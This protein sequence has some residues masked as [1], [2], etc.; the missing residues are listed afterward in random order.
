MASRIPASA[1]RLDVYKVA[2]QLVAAV[3][4]LIPRIAQRNSKLGTQLKGALP[5]VPQNISEGLRRTGNDR[6]HL[7]TVALGSAD[8]VRCVLEARSEEDEAGLFAGRV[9]RIS[10]V[11]DASTGTIKV[12]LSLESPPASVRPGTFMRVEIRKDVHENALLVSKR[13][14]VYEASSTYVFRTDGEKVER[15]PVA[16]GLEN[17]SNVEVYDYAWR[18]IVDDADV[19][20]RETETLEQLG[21]EC[22]RFLR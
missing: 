15:V 22:N 2:L 17:D 3:T 10:P 7:L 18:L 1:R 4:P 5:S 12:R 13:A 21:A 19:L 20:D 8:E 16:L 11:V 14:L 9:E 6:A